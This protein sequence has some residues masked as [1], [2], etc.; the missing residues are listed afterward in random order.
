MVPDASRSICSKT[1]DRMRLCPCFLCSILLSNCT[2]V[3]ALK[4]AVAVNEQGDVDTDTL[5]N[6][7]STIIAESKVN[8]VNEEIISGKHREAETTKDKA[9]PSITPRNTTMI[10]SPSPFIDLF[11]ENLMYLAPTELGKGIQ[12][13]AIPT[14]EALAGKNVVGVYFSA[15]WCGPCRK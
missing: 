13:L 14:T 2:I 11:G 7:E 10:K 3:H 8:A 1:I 6:Q 15:D 5:E 12:P 4:V 9:S